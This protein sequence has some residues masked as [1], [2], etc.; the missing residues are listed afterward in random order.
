MLVQRGQNEIM[1]AIAVLGLRRE[2]GHC[3]VGLLLP[4]DVACENALRRGIQLIESDSRR[5][6]S[7][8]VVEVIERVFGQ[9]TRVGA[10]GEVLD[11][12]GVLKR[13]I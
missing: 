6:E 11:A 5:V 2:D 3:R 1:D 4:G 10:E 7:L 12:R 8:E 13:V 9:V